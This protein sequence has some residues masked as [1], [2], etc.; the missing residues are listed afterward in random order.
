MR[1]IKCHVIIIVIATLF[2]QFLLSVH[3]AH[4]D[5]T[6]NVYI[7]DSRTVQ[8]YGALTG[9]YKSDLTA[10]DSTGIWVAKGAEGYSWF[11]N[12]GMP[13][14]KKY[15][16]GHNLIIL[17]GANDMISTGTAYSYVTYL[18]D[19]AS[20]FAENNTDV[21][22]VSVNPV[23]HTN[24]GND[25]SYYS[26]SNNT[27]VAFNNV[28]KNNL[29]SYVTYIDTYNYLLQTGY[30]TTDGIHYDNTTYLNIYNYVNSAVDDKGIIIEDI[31]STET[32]TNTSNNDRDITDNDDG[33]IIE[34][35][36]PGTCTITLTGQNNTD[37]VTVS[38]TENTKIGTLPNPA[39]KP[40]YKFTGWY[41]APDNG[42]LV[43]PTGL[44][45]NDMEFFAHWEPNGTTKYTVTRMIETLNGEYKE[46]DTYTETGNADSKI[47]VSPEPIDGF[48]AP[49]EKTITLKADDSSSVTFQYSR[50]SYKIKLTTGE[51]VTSKQKTFTYQYQAPVTLNVF[52]NE[53]YA[54]MVITGDV[55]S[56]KFNMPAQDVT[57]NISAS[58]TVYKIMYRGNGI[59]TEGL[60]TEYSL[61]ML[62][63]TLPKPATT[64]VLWQFNCWRYDG[65]PISVIDNTDHTDIVLIAD[66]TF[67]WQYLMPFL[68][69]IAFLI[70]I[71]LLLR[72]S[73]KKKHQSNSE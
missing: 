4:A 23:G 19:N 62:P 13:N 66:T 52:L 54:N 15:A 71:I 51:G 41:T 9:T 1:N 2:I 5:A 31:I 36:T 22:F 25:T 32:I 24:G 39:A 60:P 43:N 12:T 18:N 10:S 67:Q 33:I 40:G 64:S 70:P 28:I 30:S 61:S 44:I 46:Y 72:Q 14:A 50:N 58:P 7:G 16:N 8:M 73:K 42:T 49:N 69:G 27:C 3:P 48:T 21:Y 47:T 38:R 37:P 56:K 45:E 63:I 65:R 35:I 68:I 55:T 6:S 57:V 34:K 53:D 17:M 20:Y 26:L 59:T 29:P 11:E